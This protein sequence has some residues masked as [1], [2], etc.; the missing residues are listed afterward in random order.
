VLTNKPQG[1]ADLLLPLLGLDGYFAA[2]Y[3][4]GRK[5]YTKPDPRIFHD[6]VEDCG[7]GPAVMIG[8]SVTD[9]GTARAA[10]VPAILFSYGYTPVPAREL[11]ADIVLDDFRELPGALRRLGF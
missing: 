10:G 7:G 6:V 3:G 2:I 9:L 11:N 8:D 5:P 1:L 4:A